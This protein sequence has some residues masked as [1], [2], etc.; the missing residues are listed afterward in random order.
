[1]TKHGRNARMIA[2]LI[3]G[4]L[5]TYYLLSRSG[6]LESTVSNIFTALGRA[7]T[8]WLLI[9]LLLFAI[10]QLL[11]AWR[12][13]ILSWNHDIELRQSLPLTAVHVGLAHL[14]PVRLSDVALV[15]LFKK[16]AS[17]PLGNG[18]ATVILAKIMDVIAMGFVV[19][20]SFVAGLSGPVVYVAASASAI[21]LLSLFFLPFILSLLIKPIKTIF[22]TG[23]FASSWLE[24][25]EATEITS[26]RKSRVTL[27]MGLS[28][29]G[30]AVKLFMFYALLRSVGVHGLPMWQIFTASAITDLIMALPVH[31]LLSLGTVEAGWVAGFKLTGVSGILPG[32]LSVIEAGFSV[33]LLWLSMAVLLMLGGTAALLLSGRKG[34]I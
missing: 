16:Y 9:S 27:A 7:D 10:T 15:G 26:G 29:A 30:W 12:W 24:L 22:G 31:G 17:V 18:A 8:L 6:S 19:A 1:M 34:T 2:L 28:I 32:G 21:G 23:R 25:A 3:V 5:L 33:H 4:A 13:Q 14:L 11:R 20:C